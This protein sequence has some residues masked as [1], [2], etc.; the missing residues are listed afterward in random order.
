MPGREV[1]RSVEDSQEGGYEA[2]ALRHFVFT[3]ANSLEGLKAMIRDAVCY[4]FENGQNPAV[5]RVEL[6]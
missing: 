6:V 4:H 5:I 3:Q 2:R 1:I